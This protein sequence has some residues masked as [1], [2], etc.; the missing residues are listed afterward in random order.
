M[1]LEPAECIVAGDRGAQRRS[2]RSAE[3]KVTMKGANLSERLSLDILLNNK[4]V[5]VRVRAI[6]QI[7]T[8]RSNV[9]CLAVG[10][11]CTVPA[12]PMEKYKHWS[13]TIVCTV[14]T[15]AHC[16]FLK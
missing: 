11:Y 2:C 10:Y 9:S 3:T 14:N 4:S 5:R 1:S 6:S 8:A 16:A 13:F 12:L 15:V 7:V